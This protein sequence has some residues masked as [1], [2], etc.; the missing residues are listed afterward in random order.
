MNTTFD[1]SDLLSEL[2]VE[3][4]HLTI[5]PVSVIDIMAQGKRQ[6]ENHGSTSSRANYSPFPSEIATLCYEFYL[7]DASL[8]FDP[9]AGWGER[10]AAAR[11]N[12]KGYIGYDCSAEAVEKALKDYGVENQLCD[13]MYADIPEFDGLLTC[14][15]YWNLEK[16][17]DPRGLDREKTWAD[18]LRKLDCVFMRCYTAAK[19]GTIFCVMVGDWRK[20]HV[21]YDLEWNVCE[22]FKGL[23]AQIVDKVVV[24]RSKVSKIKIM[25]PQAKR[26]GYSVRVHENLLVFKKPNGQRPPQRGA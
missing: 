3:S 26:L 9:F 1:K 24:S 20:D 17:A 8:V 6:N 10:A 11:Q 15:P 5:M 12:G 25:L 23:G 19:E 14:P 21:Y 22:M 4:G 13:S 7:R 2:P 18:F 16:Y